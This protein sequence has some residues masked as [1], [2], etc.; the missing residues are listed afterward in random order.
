MGRV[1]GEAKVSLNRGEEGCA[2]LEPGRLGVMYIWPE[3]CVE[4]EPGRLATLGGRSEKL[5]E[6]DVET[7]AETVWVASGNGYESR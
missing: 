2:E 5:A 1:G 4:R 6:T 7:D 3:V